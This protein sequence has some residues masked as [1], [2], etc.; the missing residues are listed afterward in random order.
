[1]LEKCEVLTSLDTCEEV[2]TSKTY[3]IT[4]DPEKSLT[5]K[6]RALLQKNK[7]ELFTK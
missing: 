7:N 6:L 1:M 4:R 5:P 2:I 3:G